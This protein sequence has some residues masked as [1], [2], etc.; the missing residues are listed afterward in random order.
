MHHPPLP[1]RLAPCAYFLG[2]FPGPPYVTGFLSCPSGLPLRRSPACLSLELF[3]GLLSFRRLWFP[4][5]SSL[6]V[7]H[8]SPPCLSSCLSQGF[9]WLGW[10]R[11]PYSS[12][13]ICR[14]PSVRRPSLGFGPNHSIS[15]LRLF[16][17]VLGGAALRAF[18]LS[19][20][21]VSSRFALSFCRH[22]L[23]ASLCCW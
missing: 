15:F 12:V 3:L 23:W 10:L 16:L 20:L 6:A 1:S 17:S 5:L 4:V 8:F 13:V 18:L 14:L 7:S 22:V 2:G 21:L 9:L 11:P 19:R